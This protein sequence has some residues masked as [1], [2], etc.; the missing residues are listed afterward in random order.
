LLSNKEEEGEE[1][2]EVGEEEEVQ[3]LLSVAAF[4]FITSREEG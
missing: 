1:E 2:L 3:L 4:Q